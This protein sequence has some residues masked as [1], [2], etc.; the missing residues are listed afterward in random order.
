MSC[1][2]GSVGGVGEGG[3][4]EACPANGGVLRGQTKLNGSD[5]PS[6][7]SNRGLNQTVLVVEFSCTPEP[8]ITFCVFLSTPFELYALTSI[9]VQTSIFQLF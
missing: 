4:V 3:P 9:F 1:R 7:G 8:H 5:Q 2:G 6:Y